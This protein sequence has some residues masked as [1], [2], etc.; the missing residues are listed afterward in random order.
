VNTR[1]DY[2]PTLVKFQCVKQHVT[3]IKFMPTAVIIIIIF[4][5]KFK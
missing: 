5:T 4:P 1:R 2:Y 3:E